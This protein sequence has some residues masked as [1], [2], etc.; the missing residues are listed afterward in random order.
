LPWE[1]GLTRPP[2][3]QRRQG[4]Q[5]LETLISPEVQAVVRPFENSLTILNEADFGYRHI[6]KYLADCQAGARVL[7]VGS[8]P[9]VLLSQ[10]KTDFPLLEVTGVEPIGPG[11]DNFDST[12]QELTEK[13]GFRL[14]KIGYEDLD[15]PSRFDLIFLVN[16]FEHL[17]DWRHFLGFVAEKLKPDGK[18][19]ILCPNYGFPYESHFKLPILLNKSLTYRLF[20]NE[21]ER[22]EAEY[23]RHGLWDSLNFVRWSEVKKRAP[24]CGLNI[25]FKSSILREMVERLQY[26]AAFA[27]RQEKIARLARLALGAGIVRLLESPVFYRFNPYMFLEI[28]SSRSADG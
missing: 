12:L 8:G 2:G 10:L 9:C 3:K 1:V 27:Q 22:S 17:P 15:D 28:T 7:E 11:F 14:L 26:D 24:Q 6:R 19:I 21:I 23:G 20:R 25:T 18:C 4:W 16:V 13:F 5:A